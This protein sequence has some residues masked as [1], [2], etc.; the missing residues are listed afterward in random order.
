MVYQATKI[1]VDKVILHCFVLR[2]LGLDEIDGAS[3]IEGV[4]VAKT[5]KVSNAIINGLDGA[6]LAFTHDWG[7]K[8]PSW[9]YPDPCSNWDGV[10]CI[11]SRVTS[12]LFSSLGLAG[13]LTADIITLS[14]L[15]ILDLSNNQELTGN[16]PHNTGELRQLKSLILVGCGFSGSIPD[17]VGSL[18][19]LVF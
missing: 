18:Q 8:P 6:L 1:N 15:Q 14:A 13:Q 9:N 4:P 10:S 7:N 3:G 12:I 5:L 17:S 11:N 16:L 19:Q 2:K